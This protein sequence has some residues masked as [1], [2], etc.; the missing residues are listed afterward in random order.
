MLDECL[1]VEWLLLLLLHLLL[2]LL[3]ALE[4]RGDNLKLVH[5]ELGLR[6]GHRL[7]LADRRVVPVLHLG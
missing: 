1:V 7:L 4:K 6:L 3:L 5:A 2:M